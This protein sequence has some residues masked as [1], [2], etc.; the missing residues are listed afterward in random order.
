[1]AAITPSL[2][3]LES[4]GSASANWSRTS[5]DEEEF[6]R[7]SNTC[8]LAEDVLATHGI[9][10]YEAYLAEL[11]ECRTADRI[12]AQ[13]RHQK[14]LAHKAAIKHCLK[15]LKKFAEVCQKHLVDNNYSVWLDQIKLA[16]HDQLGWKQIVSTGA[17]AQDHISGTVRGWFADGPKFIVNQLTTTAAIDAN[18][19][20]GC[21]GQRQSP[22][23]LVITFRLETV[24]AAVGSYAPSQ[25]LL[26]P[27]PLS[28]STATNSRVV[29]S[30]S[31]GILS[32]I[33]IL[34]SIGIT[35]I[36]SIIGI[37]EIV[38]KISVSSINVA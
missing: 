12:E 15:K 35:S 23:Q 18:S 1:M 29:I 34:G 25:K 7:Y 9:V 8:P 10:T 16:F 26:P 13:E 38:S 36:N 28:V 4:I 14:K 37:N 5:D 2:S 32:R 6:R 30:T 3:S 11:Q 22:A 33:G 17:D 31:I 24:I 21:Q 19:R 20:I 27:L